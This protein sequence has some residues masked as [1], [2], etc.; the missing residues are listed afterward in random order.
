MLW[1]PQQPDNFLS[2]LCLT[3]IQCSG[4]FPKSAFG[5]LCIVTLVRVLPTGRFD[6]LWY[7]AATLI[8]ADMH[9]MTCTVGGQKGTAKGTWHMR[10]LKEELAMDTEGYFQFLWDHAHCH[11]YLCDFKRHPACTWWLRY[12]SIHV[13]DHWWNWMVVIF[14]VS[15]FHRKYL[16]WNVCSMVVLYWG[17]SST[18]QCVWFFQI[19]GMVLKG[20]FIS[21]LIV[22]DAEGKKQ[23]IF[24]SH[25]RVVFFLR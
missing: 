7:C 14:G 10:W 25:V 12:R 24:V 23:D 17:D 4:E 21:M 20:F 18:W 1:K 13:C 16:W 9:L 22:S 2:Y 11:A 15:F 19:F 5:W 6:R 8:C 3:P